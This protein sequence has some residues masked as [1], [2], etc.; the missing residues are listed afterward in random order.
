MAVGVNPPS[1]LKIIG[2]WPS[3]LYAW[4]SRLYGGGPHDFS[5]SP[6]PLLTNLVW[7]GFGPRGILGT[8][9]WGQGLTTG[10]LKSLLRIYHSQKTLFN[11]H[12]DTEILFNGTFCPHKKLL[13]L[14][15]FYIL[16]FMSPLNVQR[17][18]YFARQLSKFQ[19]VLWQSV[20]GKF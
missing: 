8:K 12:S 6:S 17:K 13:L 15:T 19:D 5:V 10:S 2:G 14:L 1:C 9:V 18:F 16:T 3:L 11:R 20:R 7:F 4:P